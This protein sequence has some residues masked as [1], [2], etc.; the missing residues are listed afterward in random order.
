[1]QEQEV[2]RGVLAL[3]QRIAPE[4]EPAQLDGRVALREQVDLDSMDFLR[5]LISIHEQYA[6]DIPEADYEKLVSLD[7]IVAYLRARLPT[8]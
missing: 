1:M 2:Q 7:D 8:S 5:F 4:L 3:L 6:I